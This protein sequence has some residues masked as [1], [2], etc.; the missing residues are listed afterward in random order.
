[1]GTFLQ[2]LGVTLIIGAILAGLGW[3]IFRQRKQW[4]HGTPSQVHGVYPT[5]RRY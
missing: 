3:L 2:G 4:K 1:M 5:K